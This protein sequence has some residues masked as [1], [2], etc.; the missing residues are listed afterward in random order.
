M[1]EIIIK[2]ENPKQD[3]TEDGNDSLHTKC[4]KSVFD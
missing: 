3:V 2:G 1:V 4:S